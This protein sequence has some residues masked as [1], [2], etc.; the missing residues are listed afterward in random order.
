MQIWF[1]VRVQQP[2]YHDWRSLVPPQSLL[3]SP[4]SVRHPGGRFDFAIISDT[5]QS[6]WPSNGLRGMFSKDNTSI[7]SLLTGHAVV[8]IRLIF[9]LLRS[10]TFFAYVQHFHATTPLPSNTTD[11]AAGMHV[12]KCVIT[13]DGMRVGKIIPLHYICSPAH[14]IL[15]FGKEANP[16][17]ARH[18]CYE[19][20]RKFWLNKYWSKEFYYALS[21]N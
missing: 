17:L 7:C 12:L 19:L 9:C 1:K 8:Q 11:N 4:P 18:T 10:D 14:V 2:T 15:H 5:G 20:S 6:D 13:S 21:L 3:A 16:H